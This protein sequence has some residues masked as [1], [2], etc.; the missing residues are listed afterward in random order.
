MSAEGQQL[1]IDINREQAQIFV[2][3]ADLARLLA[4]GPE[5]Y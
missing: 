3:G 4:S 5:W 2:E 1:M